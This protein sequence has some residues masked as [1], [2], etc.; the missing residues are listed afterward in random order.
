MEFRPVLRRA[1]ATIS[2]QKTAELWHQRLGRI[3]SAYVQAS[4]RTG[5]VTGISLKDVG[6]GFR[7]GH[8]EIGKQAR[9]PFPRVTTDD[10]FKPGQKIYSDIAGKMLV[11]FLGGKNFFR[12][13]KDHA[14][15]FRMAY[16]LAHK[17]ETPN[18]DKEFVKCM[19]TLPTVNSGS[20]QKQL[21][22]LTCTFKESLFTVLKSSLKCLKITSG[23]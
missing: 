6:E 5:A 20:L 9:K 19:E 23:S 22:S 7:C 14:T 11:K 12:L 3:N 4:V 16:F 18:K 13:V 17:D 10:N 15:G 21:N 8:C 1:H 2:S